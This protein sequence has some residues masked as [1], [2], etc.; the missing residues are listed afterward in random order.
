MIIALTINSITGIKNK[1]FVFTIMLITNFICCL[2][3][4]AT[5]FVGQLINGKK[6]K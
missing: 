4:I 5:V 3:C 1:N 6:N 2:L